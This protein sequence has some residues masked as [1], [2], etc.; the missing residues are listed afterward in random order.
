M[1][2]SPVVIGSVGVALLLLAFFL[3]L[4]KFMRQDSKAYALMNV[5]GGGLS[6]YASFLIS[7][8]PFVILEA[9][10]MLVALAGLVKMIMKENG[11]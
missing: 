4:F 6:A 7:F 1:F 5:L 11:E 2:E 9:T 10:W 8:M 3:T